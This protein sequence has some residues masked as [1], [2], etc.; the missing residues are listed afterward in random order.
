MPLTR[1]WLLG[2][3]SLSAEFVIGPEVIVGVVS[4]DTIAG[5]IP[6]DP[7]ITGVIEDENPPP[8]TTTSF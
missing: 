7:A 4:D 8:P 5:V 6:D 1:L 3:G 2:G